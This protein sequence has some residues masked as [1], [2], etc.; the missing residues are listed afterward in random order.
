[1]LVGPAA[2]TVEALPIIHAKIFEVFKQ[3]VIGSITS[4]GITAEL[5]AVW[6]HLAEHV[7]LIYDRVVTREALHEGKPPQQPVHAC[8]YTQ[9]RPVAVAWEGQQ[10]GETT[11]VGLGVTHLYLH[12][13]RD[14]P[15]LGGLDGGAL[16][17]T[18]P[19]LP[20]VEE[21]HAIPE[22]GSSLDTLSLG[23]GNVG[24][25]IQGKHQFVHFALLDDHCGLGLEAAVLEV[26]EVPGLVPAHGWALDGVAGPAARVVLTRAGWL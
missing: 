8:H 1:M 7:A 11:T 17:A 26:L 4:K 6:G 9:L 21:V 10:A 16:G 23:G 20:E 2:E 18:L 15:D 25:V 14:D 13:A 24:G 12:A 5:P 19:A 22:Q 3:A